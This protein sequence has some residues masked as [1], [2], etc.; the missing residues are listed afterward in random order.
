MAPPTA[1]LVRAAA[2]AYLANCALGVA[3]AT[4][5]VDTSRHRWVHH[6]LYVVTASLT[7]AAVASGALARRAPGLVLAPALAPL[8]LLPRAGHA[9][10]ARTALAAAPWYG[11]ALLVRQEG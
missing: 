6:A 3:V 10:H 9:V 11:L 8:A 4:R 1:G 2:G 5:I 7:A